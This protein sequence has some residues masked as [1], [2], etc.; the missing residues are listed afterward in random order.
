MLA[1]SFLVR[2][3]LFERRREFEK[4][5]GRG[6]ECILKDTLETKIVAT[7]KGIPLP[8]DHLLRQDPNCVEPLM[9]GRS[10]N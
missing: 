5:L 9:P 6:A 3:K 4:E 1:N 8:T 2:S 7:V 10:V